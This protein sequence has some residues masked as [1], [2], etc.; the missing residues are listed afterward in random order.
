MR[1]VVLM[2]L[3]VLAL[4]ACQKN[5]EKAA[6]EGEAAGPAAQAPAN[7]SAGAPAGPPARKPGLWTISTSTAGMTQEIRTCIDAATDKEMSAWGQ[8]VS[9]DMCSKNEVRPAAGGWAF[10]SV[11][12]MGQ[13]GTMTTKGSATGDF[14]SRYVVKATTVTTGS[15]MPQANGTHDMTMTATWSGP[16]PADMKPGDMV[17]PGGMK[18]TR[19]MMRGMQGR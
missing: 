13:G 11:C 16:C 18:V 19:E 8:Q 15:S 7:A 17:M 1:R 5:E 14:N 3:S 6:A 10:E 12:S 2:G 9:N 4:S